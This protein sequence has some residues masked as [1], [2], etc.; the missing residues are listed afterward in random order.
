[1]AKKKEETLQRILTAL[2]PYAPLV[3]IV[4]GLPLH[5]SGKESPLSSEVRIFAKE[6]EIAFKI[7]VILWDERLTSAQVERTLKE[8]EMS[9]K[10]RTALV[11][12]MAAAVILQNYLDHLGSNRG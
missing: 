8:A 1:M 7:P 9:R 11:D 4:I 10:K 2:S 5:L 6:L 3:S 12:A